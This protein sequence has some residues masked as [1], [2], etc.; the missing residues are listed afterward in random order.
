MAPKDWNPKVTISEAQLSQLISENVRVI[1]RLGW[2]SLDPLEITEHLS[3]FLKGLARWTVRMSKVELRQ[4]LMRSKV[5][6]KQ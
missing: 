5:S 4:S 1:E 6:L 2:K 3:A